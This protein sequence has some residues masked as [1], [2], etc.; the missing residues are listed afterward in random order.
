MSGCSLDC[1]PPETVQNIRRFMISVKAEGA[2]AFADSRAVKSALEKA[3]R[4]LRQVRTGDSPGNEWLGW[5]RILASPDEGEIRR[6]EET[7]G[8]IRQECDVFIV[9]G[10]G[11]SYLG[12]RAVIEALRGFFPENGPEILYAGHHLGGRYLEDLLRYLD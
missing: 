7:A 5:R 8:Q 9:C 11:G 6:I 4:A 12:A 3:E 10:I 2:R 1:S